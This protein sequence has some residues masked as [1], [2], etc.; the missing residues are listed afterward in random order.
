MT[1]IVYGGIIAGLVLVFLYILAA[2]D[3][4]G[5]GNIIIEERTAGGEIEDP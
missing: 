4:G 5:S 3:S 2:T 1:Y